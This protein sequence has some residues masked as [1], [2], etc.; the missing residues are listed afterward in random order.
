MKFQNHIQILILFLVFSKVVS[1]SNIQ[2]LLEPHLSSCTPILVYLKHSI[3]SPATFEA[4]ENHE[5]I[6]N[7]LQNYKIPLIKYKIGLNKTFPLQ[8]TIKYSNRFFDRCVTAIVQ[9]QKVIKTDSFSF[10]SIKLSIEDLEKKL[11]PS[12]KNSSCSTLLRT[13]QD[14]VVFWTFTDEDKEEDSFK[15]RE[16]IL[17]STFS[18]RLKFKVFFEIVQN[19]RESAFTSCEFCG[20]HGIIQLPL[21]PGIQTICPIFIKNHIFFYKNPDAELFPD[22]HHKLHGHTFQLIVAEG[23]RGRMNYTFNE[24]QGHFTL[25]NG[26]IKPVVEY[27]AYRLNFSYEIIPSL[28]GGGTGIKLQNGSWDGL[29]ADIMLSDGGALAFSVAQ[30]ADRSQVVGFTDAGIMYF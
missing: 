25:T 10:S 20:I 30:T 26:M 6:I 5:I 11:S 22:F 9:I 24:T 1:A 19:V 23:L 13:D 29:V 12:P 8:S 28:R 14:K 15:I 7:E 18:S 4:H 16:T 17:K 27:L 21:V 3:T 2:K